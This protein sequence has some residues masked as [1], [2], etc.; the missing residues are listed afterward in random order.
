MGFTLAEI[1]L[2]ISIILILSVTG[3]YYFSK[4]GSA[5]ALEKD[6]QG[7]VAILEEARSLTLAGKNASVYGVHVEIDA[8]Y[9]FEGTTYVNNDPDNKVLRFHSTVTASNIALTSGSAVNFSKLT[10]E[11]STYGSITLSL[12]ENPSITKVVTILNTGVIQ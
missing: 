2:S 8:A 6:R 1:I 12:V 7:L 5:H 11:A 3:L 9:L 4:G 10:G